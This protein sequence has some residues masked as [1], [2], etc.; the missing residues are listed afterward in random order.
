M[1]GWPRTGSGTNS[2]GGAVMNAR[3]LP[4]SS[5]AASM[6]SRQKRTT[7]RAIAAG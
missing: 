2:S 3:P 5:G 6:K 1:T 7:S 4:T